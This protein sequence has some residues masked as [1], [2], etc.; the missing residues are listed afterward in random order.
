M[1]SHLRKAVPHR[2]IHTDNYYRWLSGRINLATVKTPDR[3]I[4]EL[5]FA[6]RCLEAGS[7][8]PNVMPQ[9]GR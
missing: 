2:R 8:P 6:R 3:L 1:P 4:F 9:T 5:R 7:V